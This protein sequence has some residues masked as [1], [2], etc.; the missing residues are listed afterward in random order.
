MTDYS[1]V[2]NEAP[3]VRWSSEESFFTGITF[4]FFLKYD[5]LVDPIYKGPRVYLR[6]KVN[7]SQQEIII[8]VFRKK[9]EITRKSSFG[10]P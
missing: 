10:L 8:T 3:I 2:A 1:G 5:I 9:G 7:F 4:F 6:I